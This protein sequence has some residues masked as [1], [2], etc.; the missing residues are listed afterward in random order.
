[1]RDKKGFGGLY[2]D[3]PEWSGG[4]IKRVEMA[5]KEKKSNKLRRKWDESSVVWIWAGLLMFLLSIWSGIL[6]TII[7][8]MRG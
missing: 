8:L 2:R 1:M 5:K 6:Y 4:F 3:G 7:K